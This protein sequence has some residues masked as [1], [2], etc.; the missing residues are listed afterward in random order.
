MPSCFVNEFEELFRKYGWNYA[1]INSL[2]YLLFYTGIIFM[3]N[4]L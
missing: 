4:Q 3:L 2:E 1:D